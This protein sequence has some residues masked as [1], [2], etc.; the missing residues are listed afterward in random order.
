M[1]EESYAIIRSL[2]D[3][4]SVRIDFKRTMQKGKIMDFSI[5]V[6]LIEEEK[7]TEIY[8]I[9]TEHGYIHEHKFWKSKDPI[10]IDMEYNKCFAEKEIEIMENYRRWILLFKKKE[11]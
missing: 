9:D 4:D 1:P 5:N 8:R 3:G 11:I 6:C 10:K 2:E 7:N